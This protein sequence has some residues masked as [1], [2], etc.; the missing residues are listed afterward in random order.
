LR[1]GCRVRKTSAAAH[2][3]FQASLDRRSC[4]PVATGQTLRK[5]PGMGSE[6]G[7]GTAGEVQLQAAPATLEARAS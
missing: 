2:L 6:H 5:R 1:R 4:L 7:G 3:V